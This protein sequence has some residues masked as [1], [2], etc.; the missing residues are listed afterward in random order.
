[1]LQRF[2]DALSALIAAALAG[3]AAVGRVAW[4]L[5]R[6]S[7]FGALNVIA[8]LVVLFEEWGWRPLA[9]ALDYLARFRLWAC[10]EEAIRRLPPYAALVVFALPTTILLPL[11][12]A[13]IWLVARGY[14]LTAGA[15][16]VAAKVVSTALVA[17]LFMLTQPA[18]MQIG[19]FARAYT[20]F[21]PWKEALFA[22]IRASW[23][24]RYGRMVKAR[25]ERTVR[26]GW[27]RLR[28]R[29]DAIRHS[30]GLAVGRSWRRLRRA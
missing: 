14:I 22:R 24:W 30:L 9:Q 6:G 25:A 29:L 18:L 26:Q 2:L 27:A 4:R 12:F 15:L 20:W 3:I 28:P 5:A 19:W 8:A 7:L 1:M 13:A 21:V 11:K 16:F 10:V 17:R 23:A